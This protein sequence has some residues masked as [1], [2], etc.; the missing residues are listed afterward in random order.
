MNIQNIILDINKT[1]LN[2]ITQLVELI[3]MKKLRFKMSI[4]TLIKNKFFITFSET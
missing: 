4:Y 1:H 2:L 3:L